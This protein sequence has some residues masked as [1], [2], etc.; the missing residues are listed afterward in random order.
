MK[1]ELTCHFSRCGG[2]WSSSIGFNVTS[3]VIVS[4]NRMRMMNVVVDDEE[5]DNNNV[6][7][8]DED[9]DECW[10]CCCR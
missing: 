1:S 10:C 6:G 5:E 9:D 8:V 3:S 2:S 7:E 4:V